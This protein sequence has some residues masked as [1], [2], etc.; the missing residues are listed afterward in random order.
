MP[1]FGASSAAL[2]TFNENS[3]V[4]PGNYPQ[5]AY[6]QAGG[7][8]MAQTKPS[9]NEMGDSIIDLHFQQPVQGAL[10]LQEQGPHRP[11]AP[12]VGPDVGKGGCVSRG[13]GLGAAVPGVGGSQSR[14][15]TSCCA[16]TAV[17]RSLPQ[18]GR[19]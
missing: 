5:E 12:A 13:G 3:Q 8:N 4:L 2:I 1:K 10:F 9:S 17:L 11:A 15:S 16:L 19:R 18:S 7:E 6:C 14:G